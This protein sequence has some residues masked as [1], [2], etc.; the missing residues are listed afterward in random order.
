MEVKVTSKEYYDFRE[1]ENT[2]QVSLL[3]LLKGAL[4]RW[5]IILLAGVVLGCILGSYK[6]LSIHSKKEAMI[7]DYDTYVSK[8]DAYRTSIKE[9]KVMIKALQE[10][11]EEK[12]SYMDSSIR[13]NLD[14]YNV[15]MATADF[16][17]T[18]DK[19]LTSDQ[20]AAIRTGIYNE[21]FFGKSS[22]EV[23]KKHDLDPTALREL[24]T[25][26]IAT[27]GPTI[28]FT[29]RGTDEET[30]VAVREDLIAEVEKKRPELVKAFGNFTLKR[31]NDSIIVGYDSET[32]SFQEKQND[33]LTKLQTS[34]YTAQNQSNQ[35]T[36]PV[37]VPQY[38]KKY[39][40]SG[41][42]KMGIVGLVG[43]IA[44]ALAAVIASLIAK[45]VIFSAEEVDGEFG[46][47]NLGDLS[48]T[49]LE[50]ADDKLDYISAGIDNYIKD[51]KAKVAFVG[52]ADA[53]K[54]G[55]LMDSLSKKVRSSA[56]FVYLPDLLVNA[57]SL[58]KLPDVDSVVLVEEIGRS[59][60]M[61]ARKEIA[62]I[63]GSGREIIGT[64]YM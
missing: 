6:I 5:K 39:M 46:L 14:A 47:C 20:L 35:L 61:N 50:K 63:A 56:E 32:F 30:A 24:I 29:V 26:K 12:L 64:V 17:V 60:Y 44:L 1:E 18:S 11:I 33:A 59:D 19:K 23:A 48:D 62:L 49:K 51:S 55:A 22:D 42:I 13:M 25:V 21:V 27:S 10:Q 43:G 36:K 8:R 2:R 38:S 37:A 58:R 31:F 28:R 3:T 9:Y 45:G 52:Q 4:K 15:P 7:E 41:G 34:A 53:N 16:T 57:A 40:L 54:V